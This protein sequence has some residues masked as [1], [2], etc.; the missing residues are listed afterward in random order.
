M[1]KYF[2]L[3]NPK[4]VIKINFM[5]TR[6]RGSRHSF[7][8]YLTNGDQN[9]IESFLSCFPSF[10]LYASRTGES[11]NSILTSY[12]HRGCSFRQHKKVCGTLTKTG[13]QCFSSY[14]HIWNG[15]LACTAELKSL[16]ISFKKMICKLESETKRRKNWPRA[17]DEKRCS[18]SCWLPRIP[19][20]RKNHCT[21]FGKPQ[22]MV[23]NWL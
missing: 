19:K 12:K 22:K 20:E 10:R 4:L 2:Q 8:N 18:T 17:R 3:F 16:D 13:L 9:N 6:R 21:T 15:Y 23:I 1:W 11:I 14:K 5:L 7:I